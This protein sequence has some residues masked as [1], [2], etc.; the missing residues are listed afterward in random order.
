MV[1]LSVSVE[2]MLPS[3]VGV[4]EPLA[5]EAVTPAGNPLTESAIAPG[6]VPPVVVVIEELAEEPC[7]TVISLSC[8]LRR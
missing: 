6:K 3:T 4:N 8:A 5:H 2:T 1:D 7:T